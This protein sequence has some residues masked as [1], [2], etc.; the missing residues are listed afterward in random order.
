MK[1]AEKR[2]LPI[3]MITISLVIASCR[4]AKPF[5]CIWQNPLDYSYNYLIKPDSTEIAKIKTFIKYIDSL[6][7]K[8]ETQEFV[9][10][11]IAEGKITQETT[12]LANTGQHNKADTTF[13]VKNGGF[14]KYTTENLKGDTVYKILY[15]DNIDKNY[16]EMFY[17]KD[18]NLVYS[19]IDYQNDGIGQ[20]FYY[21]EEYYKDNDTLMINES[22]EPIDN[23][24]RQRVT[25]DLRKK[26]TDYLNQFKSERK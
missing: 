25:F 24:Y 16:Y 15:H 8:D 11:S 13:N 5:S 12:T 1:I 20:T 4:T 21:R 22:T 2:Y 9:I 26:G 14:G 10:K 6:S 7:E 3:L 17:Y 23:A 18:N 19:R